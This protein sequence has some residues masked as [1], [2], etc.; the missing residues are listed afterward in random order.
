MH[1][2]WIGKLNEAKAFA[3]VLGGPAQTMLAS[4][5]E[6]ARTYKDFLRR[7]QQADCDSADV[8]KP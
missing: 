3:D 1:N 8:P 2:Y 5:M 4:E 6:T 7:S